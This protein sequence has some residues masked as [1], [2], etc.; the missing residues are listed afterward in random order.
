VTE[1]GSR[2]S[3][4]A[5]TRS[6]RRHLHAHFEPNPIAFVVLSGEVA[7]VKLRKEATKKISTELIQVGFNY[8]CS[9]MDSHEQPTHV[10]RLA[11]ILA[12]VVPI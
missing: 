8:T 2:A 5:G 3:M 10:Q 7:E 9:G 1:F 11:R 4:T 6:S 12:N